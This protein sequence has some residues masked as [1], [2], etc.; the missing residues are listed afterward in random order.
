MP[1]DLLSADGAAEDDVGDPTPEELVQ[2]RQATGAEAAAV[3]ALVMSH[4]APHWRKVARVV[5]ASLNEFDANFSHLPYIY[6]QVR[7]LE[8]EDIGTLEVQ[9]D[10]MSVRSSEVRLRRPE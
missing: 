4:C 10:V 9:G 6:M 8:L 5:G 2:M 7:M 1:D 3:D